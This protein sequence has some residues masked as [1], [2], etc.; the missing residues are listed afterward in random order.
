[1][2]K[3]YDIAVI[4]GGASGLAA[5][6]TSARMAKG[7]SVAVFEKKEAT[8]K[9]LSAAGNGRCN[10]SNV[11]CEALEQVMDFFGSVG[12]ILRKDEEGRLYPYGEEGAEVTA[13]LTAC[14]RNEG[15]EIVLNS[16]ITGMEA[17]PCGGFLLFV[18]GKDSDWDGTGGKKVTAKNVL[19]ATGGKSYA[20]LGTT[21]DGY[22]LARKLGH[23]VNR[24]VPALTG[25]EVC[26]D[27]TEL[28]GVR[29]KA[30]VSLFK[31]EKMV[32]SEKGEVQF[33]ADSLSGICIMNMSRHIRRDGEYVVRI[34]PLSDFGEEELAQILQ[35]RFAIKGLTAEE[36]LKTLVKKTL[37]KYALKQVGMKA[38][39]RAITFLDT[40]TELCGGEK[41]RQKLESLAKELSCMRFKVKDLKGW[42]EA[43]VTAGGVELSEVNGVTMESKLVPGLFF[44]G[45]VLDYDGPCGGYN[46]HHA[47]LTGIRAGKGMAERC[48]EFTR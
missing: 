28:K 41:G 17:E 40:E 24:P 8:G 39:D 13:L 1:M 32:F 21:G 29:V 11:R 46:L 14:A 18:G 33:R 6:I 42:N 12:I 26:E 47:W 38:D 7:A 34:N 43:Q 48:T 5:A 2:K 4:G 36:A 15:A 30:E 45:E 27:L 9:K 25:I 10:I 31:D 35:S 22:I 44:S 19:L 16:E 23:I 20:A 3:H 37:A